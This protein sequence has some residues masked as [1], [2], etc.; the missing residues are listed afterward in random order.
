MRAIGYLTEYGS[1]S[2]REPAAGAPG[3]SDGSAAPETASGLAA[4]NDQ[5]LRFCDAN[6][7]Q[8]A[9]AFLDP[10]PRD[11]RVP[12]RPGLRQLLDYL[13]TPEKGFISVVISAFERLGPDRA[14]AARTYFQIVALGAQVI[15]IADG[16]VDDARLIEIWSQDDASAQVG[17]RVRDAMRRRAVKGQVLGRPP[18]GYRVGDN[19]RLEVIEEEAALVRVIFGLYIKEDLGIR[20]IAKRL[21]EQGYRTRRDGNWSMVTIRDLLRNRV[22]VGTYTRFGVKVPGSHTAIVSEAEFRAV[23][24]RMQQRRRPAAKAQPS[25]FLLSGLVYCGEGGPRMIGVTRR[26]QWTRRDGEVA[27]NTYRYYQSEA[28]TNQSVGEYHTRR[29]AELEAEV[30]AHLT[31]EDGPS[32]DGPAGDGPAGDG[33]AGDGP[34]GDRPAGGH[35]VR[36]A[37]LSA[38]NARAVAAEVAVAESRV[39]SHMRSLDRRV[40]NALSAASTGRKPPEYLREVAQQVTRDYQHSTDELASIDRRASAH[41][42]E[43]E[44]HRHRERQINRVRRDW[45]RLSFDERQTL[46]RDLV[47]R[48]I[49]EDDSVQTVLRV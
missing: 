8:P 17:A 23:Q 21:N 34:A 32:G 26:Q 38:G 2:A 45:G 11:G 1:Q 18:Y 41:A 47:E 16:P 19:R 30:L 48:V 42:D 40:A 35:R 29:A 4:Q 14:E 3:I 27:R 15:S 36:P 10:V 12:D 13:D 25:R 24:E 5:F 9:A 7:Y 22:Y 44:R 31:A 43:G 6:G 28:R 46:L 39:R 49:V 20:L 33:P 37:V